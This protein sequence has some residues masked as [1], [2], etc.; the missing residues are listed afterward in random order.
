MARILVSSSYIYI[1]FL[2]STHI[3]GSLILALEF[4]YAAAGVIAKSSTAIID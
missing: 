3:G 2:A 1:P 4:P